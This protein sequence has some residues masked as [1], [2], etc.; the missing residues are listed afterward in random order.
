M[1]IESFDYINGN[2][3]GEAS[4][5][6]INFGDLIQD[7]HCTK[8]LVIQFKPD[9]TG[10]SNL[11]LFLENKGEWKDT[12]YGYFIASD[13]TSNI[14]PG[15]NLFT[16]FT[17]VPDASKMDSYGVIIPWNSD[18]SCSDYVWLDADIK[19]KAGMVTANYRLF[20]D[21]SEP[22]PSFDKY[23]AYGGYYQTSNLGFG[24]DSPDLATWTTRFTAFGSYIQDMADNG[25]IIVVATW[26]GLYSTPDLTNF[27]FRAQFS[28]ISW[29]RVIWSSRLNLFIASG[30]DSGCATSPDGITWTQRNFGLTG[31]WS[32]YA[33]CEGPTSI[34]AMGTY[35]QISYST[36]GTTWTDHS[37]LTNVPFIDAIYS[38]LFSEFIAVSGQSGEM[39]LYT[40]TTGTSW[41]QT[42]YTN[43][44]PDIWISSVAE[45]NNYIYILGWGTLLI[46]NNL[47]TFDSLSIPVTDG[48]YGRLTVIDSKL[49]L[50][51]DKIGGS[52]LIV[53]SSDGN[54]FYEASS[55]IAHRVNGL[56]LKRMP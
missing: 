50:S 46:T 16:H 35:G 36:N 40:S 14:Q 25:S 1:R 12:E 27:T 49:V 41:V 5:N 32:M 29:L 44:Y 28:T 22:L 9:S 6:Q 4:L 53:Y 45:Y 42:Y 19:Q 3:L 7:Q 10:I 48:Y 18:K 51:G 33:L 47:S 54:N 43:S 2:S 21:V 37:L 38:S 20:Y 23:F 11:K 13:F 34:V 31:T 39:Y 55:S 52:G 30:T 24:I 8:P 15:S 26:S 56:L 17:E